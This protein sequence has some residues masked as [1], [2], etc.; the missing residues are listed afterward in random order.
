MM[1]GRP[2]G[3]ANGVLGYVRRGKRRRLSS[4]A[5]GVLGTAMRMVPLASSPACSLGPAVVL[6]AL[7]PCA[8]C[9]DGGV[10]VSAGAAPG[11]AS[12]GVGR[13]PPWGSFSDQYRGGPV[14]GCVLAR[15]AT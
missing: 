12:P 4:P 10:V 13:N 6:V 3:L 5:A 9:W 7:G 2:P 15:T 14:L 8:A 11:S 1:S